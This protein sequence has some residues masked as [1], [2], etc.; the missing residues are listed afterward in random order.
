MTNGMTRRPAGVCWGG[1]AVPCV[2]LVAC[3]AA[4][5]A[6]GGPADAQTEAAPA[7]VIGAV[8]L[9]R[10]LSPWSM[11]VSAD[12]VVQAVM[13]GLA[14]ASVVTW[15][16]WLAKSIELFAARRRVR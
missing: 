12:R 2:T 4:S 13:V 15:T 16:V 7:G 5:L 14:F 1:S 8:S 3:I 6:L 11:F 10:D 9:P